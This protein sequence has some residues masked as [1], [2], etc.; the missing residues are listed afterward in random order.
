MMTGFCLVRSPGR[1]LKRC[2]TAAGRDDLAA[3]EERVRHR[4][5]LIEQAARVVAQVEDDAL[6]LLAELLLARLLRQL[7]DLL[8]QAFGG[9]FV[10]LRDADVGD[11]LALE[12]RA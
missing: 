5:R 7:V 4:D 2:V 9:L 10:E 6:E 12:P 11:V 8:A 3:I 1:A